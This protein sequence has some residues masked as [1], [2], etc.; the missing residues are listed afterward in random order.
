MSNNNHF[1]VITVM[2]NMIFHILIVVMWIIQSITCVCYRSRTDYSTVKMA[3][4]R[5]RTEIL[6]YPYYSHDYSDLIVWPM[7]I[8]NNFSAPMI[9]PIGENGVVFYVYSADRCKSNKRY[10]YQVGYNA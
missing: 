8:L 9:Q 7:R 1:Y 6:L 5:M 2:L 4:R 10:F 3:S